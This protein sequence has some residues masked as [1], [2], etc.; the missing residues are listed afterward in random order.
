MCRRHRFV[1]VDLAVNLLTEKIAHG[2]DVGLVKHVLDDT[3]KYL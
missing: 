1:R 3:G 2:L